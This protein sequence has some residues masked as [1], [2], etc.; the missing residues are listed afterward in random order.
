MNMNNP[1]M[2]CHFG[3]QLLNL[4]IY[5]CVFRQRKDCG[6]YSS[7]MVSHD[8]MLLHAALAIRYVLDIFWYADTVGWYWMMAILVIEYNLCSKTYFIS[9]LCAQ[10]FPEGERSLGRAIVTLFWGWK[11]DLKILQTKLVII[12]R[13][14]D[15]N[16]DH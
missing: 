7:C 15:A 8:H 4:S 9:L 1:W 13:L 3:S 16:T 12:P 10:L 11:W 14:W 6:R 2:M 5:Y